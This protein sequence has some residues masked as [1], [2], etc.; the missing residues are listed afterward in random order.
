MPRPLPGTPVRGAFSVLDEW[1]RGVTSAGLRDALLDL[2][3]A[4]ADLGRDPARTVRTFLRLRPA[5]RQ[6]SYLCQHRL[7]R[8]LEQEIAIEIN[9]PASCWRVPLRLEWNTL[10]RTLAAP[11]RQAFEH[12]DV[13]WDAIRVRL[14]P[15]NP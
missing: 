3:G 11:R 8:A 15:K 4:C 7:R 6:G 9:T 2:R 10:D 1:V 14:V 13:D 12:G 5:L